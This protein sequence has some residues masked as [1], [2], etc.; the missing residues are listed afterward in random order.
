M[1]TARS[2]YLEAWREAIFPTARKNNSSSCVNGN[3]DFEE[4]GD[5]IP[6]GNKNRKEFWGKRRG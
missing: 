3:R 6:E 5:N 4:V 1:K 2:L